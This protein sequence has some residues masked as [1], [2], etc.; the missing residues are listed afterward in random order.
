MRCL[1]EVEVEV[2]MNNLWS[3]MDRASGQEYGPY[4]SLRLGRCGGGSRVYAE[5]KYTK[6][7]RKSSTISFPMIMIRRVRLLHS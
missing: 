7:P 2:E 4:L 5:S 6:D 1:W 3:G